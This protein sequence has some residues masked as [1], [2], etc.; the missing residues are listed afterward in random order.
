MH[1]QII[2]QLL[3]QHHRVKLGLLTS[4]N[5]TSVLGNCSKFFDMVPKLIGPHILCQMEKWAQLYVG[6][7]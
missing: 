5:S 3:S 7:I 4:L 6:L 1:Q 2:H